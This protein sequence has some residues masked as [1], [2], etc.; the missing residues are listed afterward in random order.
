MVVK[1]ESL[2]AAV[3]LSRQAPHMALG[4]ATIIRPCIEV[5]Y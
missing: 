4:G 2:D 3:A 1:A 5:A